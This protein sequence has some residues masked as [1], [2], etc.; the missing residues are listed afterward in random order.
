MSGVS[1]FRQE[2]TEAKRTDWLG[3]IVVAAPLSRWLLASL[4]SALAA[5]LVLFLAFGHYTRRS[6]VTG[7]LVPSAGLLSLVAQSAGTVTRVWVHDG[8]AVHQ[9]DPLVEIASHQESTTL[10][11]TAVLIGQQLEAQQS[12]LQADLTTQQALTEQQAN[13]LRQKASLLRAQLVQIAE[14]LAIQQKQIDSADDLLE[15]IRPLGAKGYVSA[16]QIQQQE[17]TALAA[18]DQYNSLR[19]QQLDVRQQLDATQQQFAQLP[20]NA[21]TQRNVTERQLAQVAQSLAENAMQRAIVLRA[22]RD[23]LVSTVLLKPGQAVLAGQTALS[24]LPADS[25]LLAQLLVPS[26]AVGFITTGSLVVLRYAAFPYQ[27]FGQHYGRVTD[28]S[29]SALTPAEV[30]SLSGQTSREPLYRVQVALDH[31]TVMAYGK[32][33]P[34]KPGMAVSADILMDRRSLLQWAFE[35][36]Y[37]MK[38]HLL[39]DARG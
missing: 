5:A 35:P 7:Q 30:Q 4:F 28:V 21:A 32:L 3:S 12:R 29:R 20:L 26:R 13:A 22:P 9:G 34:V 19:R 15:R 24:V 14:Q 38:N 6:T 36:L 31:Q 39:G 1:L 8:Q 25:V 23:G 33:E 37:G 2:V 16:F 18:K 27:K 10:G 17:S 11:N